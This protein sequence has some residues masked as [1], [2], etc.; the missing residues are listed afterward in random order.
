[1][2][3]CAGITIM[4]FLMG[5]LLSNNAVAN[6]Y[7]ASGVTGDWNDTVPWGGAGYP[8][9]GDVAY[10]NLG[11]TI[12]VDGTAEEAAELHLASWS[13]NSDLVTLNIANGG[14]LEILTGWT[15]VGLPLEIS[16]F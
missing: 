9:A 6:S 2:K 11:S 5:V 13:G 15:Y 10:L 8:V 7:Y 16:A 1:M 14:S 3:K 4:V 12:T